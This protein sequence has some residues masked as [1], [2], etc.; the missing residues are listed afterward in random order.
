VIKRITFR[1]DSQLIDLARQKAKSNHSSLNEEFIKWLNNFVNSPIDTS[2]VKNIY[3][4][5][6]YVKVGK[7]FSRDELNKR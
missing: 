7:T 4:Q 1:V 2:E 3:D 6:D 5:F